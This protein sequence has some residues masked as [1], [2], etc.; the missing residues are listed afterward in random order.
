[1]EDRDLDELKSEIEKVMV[2]VNEI[3]SEI[4]HLEERIENK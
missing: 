4:K 2:E 3:H 1:M